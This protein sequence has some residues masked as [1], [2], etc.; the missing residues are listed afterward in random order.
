MDLLDFV[1]VTHRF[2]VPAEALKV[3]TALDRALD[4]NGV[5][6]DRKHRQVVL[7][8]ADEPTGSQAT[9]RRYER[10]K[11]GGWEAVDEA[12]AVRVGSAGLGEGGGLYEVEMP[13]SPK[14][15]GDRSCTTGVAMKVP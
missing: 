14:R 10:A 11:E 6:L 5:E 9:L 1:P 3:A 7:V 4:R 12:V 2:R 13:L 8:E 15:E